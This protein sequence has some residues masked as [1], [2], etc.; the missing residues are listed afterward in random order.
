MRY[1]LKLIVLSLTLAACADGSYQDKTHN[2]SQV[3]AVTD[4][5][6]KVMAVFQTK[7]I[8]HD[9]L[10]VD[11]QA[12]VFVEPDSM[13]IEKEK[14]KAGEE[15]FYVVADDYM[16]YTSTAHEFLDSAKLT[17]LDASGKKFIKFISSNKTHQI[18]N[19]NKLPELGSIYFFDPT[20]KAKQVDMTVI[21]EEYK[22]YFK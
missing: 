7:T 9:T 14:K 6:Q 13:R 1:T 22:S 16:F 21:G 5:M 10:V 20:K 4:T 15:D 3:Y 2:G 18:L 8:N 12:A 19:I 11:K 17:T